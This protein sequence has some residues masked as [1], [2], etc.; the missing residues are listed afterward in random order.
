M[1]VLAR[2]LRLRDYFALAFGSMVGVGWLVVMDDWLARGGP[3]GAMLGF[4]IGGLFCCPS[5]T[6][7]VNGFNG[8]PTPPARPPT[9][10]KYFLRQ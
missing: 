2:K 5:D 6:S 4:A 3:L 10:R 9:P 1:N 8:C 7:T